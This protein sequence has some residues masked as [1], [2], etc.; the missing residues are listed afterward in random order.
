MGIPLNI[1]W[2]QILLHLFNFAILTGGLYFILYKPVKAFMNKRIEYYKSMD[3]EANKK[4]EHADQLES[5]YRKR[6][7]QADLEI[8]Q[9][10]EE[11]AQKAEAEAQETARRSKSPG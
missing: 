1:D 6:M 3:D 9:K 11:A 7:D 10:R 2:Q 8:S 4:L 5:S